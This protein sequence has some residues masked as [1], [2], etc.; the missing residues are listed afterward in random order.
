MSGLGDGEIEA[1]ETAHQDPEV[2]T[3]SGVGDLFKVEDKEF[4]GGF[5]VS[6]SDRF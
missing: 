1:V 3:E 4:K 6:E 2:L 5:Y